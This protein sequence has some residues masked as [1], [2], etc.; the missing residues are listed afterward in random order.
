MGGVVRKNLEVTLWGWG[1]VAGL[2]PTGGAGCR[3]A[4]VDCKRGRLQMCMG[5][6]RMHMGGWGLGNPHCVN[7]AQQHC[8][9]PTE[10]GSTF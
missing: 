3:C 9:C 4:W 2:P 10:K 8:F 1:T 6:L 5:R 7:K